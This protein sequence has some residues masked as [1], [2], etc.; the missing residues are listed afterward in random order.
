MPFPTL[1]QATQTE[2]RT[3]E[4]WLLEGDINR[5]DDS[6]VV[7]DLAGTAAKAGGSYPFS[8]T[9]TIGQ[10]RAEP[11]PDVAMPGANPVCHQRIVS[12]IDVD[13]LPMNGGALTLRIDPRGMLNG[14][15]FSLLTSGLRAN[16]GVYEFSWR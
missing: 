6:T 15:D 13:I 9:V 3:A 16:F 4:V 14:I 7:L 11:P 8:A 1:G 10:N 2:A 5:T 12:A